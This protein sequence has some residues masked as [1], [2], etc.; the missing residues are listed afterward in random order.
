MASLKVIKMY[1]LFII[2]TTIM[3]LFCCTP[4]EQEPCDTLLDVK[5][6]ESEYGCENTIHQL[7]ITLSDTFTIIRSQESYE[8][9]VTY[10]QGNC[11][12]NIDFSV[13]DLVIGKQSWGNQVYKIE[14][15]LV[16][17]CQTN[18]LRLT[19]RITWG[20]ATLPDTI[21]YHALIP[22]LKDEEDIEV[23]VEQLNS[24]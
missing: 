2:K 10:W 17:V 21:T 19:V 8:Q 5:S 20:D 14:Y 7:H 22:K 24:Y 16:R 18:K 23:I 12:P 1:N 13:F 11:D 9:Q 4:I 3:L 15:E 6:L